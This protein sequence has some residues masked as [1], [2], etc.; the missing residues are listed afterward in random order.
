MKTISTFLFGLFLLSFG[1]VN[2]QNAVAASV[3]NAEALI[4][5]ST[6][7]YEFGS[8]EQNV[9]ATAEFVLTNEGKQPLIITDVKKTC[10]CTVPAYNDEPIMPGESSTIK[11]TYNAKKAGPFT[12]TVKVYTTLSDQPILLKLKGNVE[13]KDEAAVTAEPDK[14]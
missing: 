11:A 9:P 13:K 5:W 8:I 10:G 7:I 2:A 4:S 14:L 6:E 1:A 3:P 12:K